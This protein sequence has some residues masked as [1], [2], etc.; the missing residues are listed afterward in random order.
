[1]IGLGRHE[2]SVA[3]A[4]VAAQAVLLTTVVVLAQAGRGVEPFSESSL[5]LD[6]F[7]ALT[8]MA[9]A[10][11]GLVIVVRR[12]GTLIGWLFVLSNLGWDVS[13][14]A[15]AWVEFGIRVAPLPAVPIAAW[16]ATWPGPLSL[17]TYVLLILL[18][19]DGRAPSPRWGRLAR[20]AIAWGVVHAT[21]SAIASGPIEALQLE[22]LEV[23]NPF[24]LPEPVGGIAAVLAY[25]VLELLSVGLLAIA[26]VSLAV[27]LRRASGV[28]REQLKWLASAV[29]VTASMYVL[30]VPIMVAYTSLADAPAW[31][32]AANAILTS[33]GFLI[34]LAA[35]VAI[36]RYRLYDIDRIV[37]RTI[38]Y[39]LVTA[40]LAA[41]FGSAVLLL[42]A[43]LASVT[44]SDTVTVAASTLLVAALFQPIRRRTQGLVDGRFNR[45]RYDAE[46]EVE[47]FVT[48]ARDE[49]DI[50]PLADALAAT[51][52]R[53]V[54]P[55]SAAVWLRAASAR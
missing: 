3:I 7:G 28:E 11:V 44:G 14:A 20:F 38:T 31:A 18:F 52:V 21:L 24:A 53:T 50:E 40:C 4:L 25:G 43:A 15:T 49:V 32:R 27:R 35:A 39:G 6:A 8:S 30:N 10:I 1:M 46:R 36:L 19:P 48:H 13:N 41:V 9:F 42:Q 55:A 51:L 45:R 33:G 22:G 16:L 23:A 12:P 54:E 34:P 2:R 17:A 26:A 47:A 29:A 37:S 5:P